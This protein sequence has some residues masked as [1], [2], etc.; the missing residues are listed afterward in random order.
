VHFGQAQIQNEQVKFIVG[1][2]G[3][4][5]FSATGHMV[6]GCTAA[7]QSSQQT[8]GQDLI[9]FCYQNAHR[10]LLLFAV[11]RLCETL[12]G[13]TVNFRRLYRL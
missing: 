12:F 8:I 2:E 1:H 6:N 7:A 9:V 10:R 13:C 4:I 3:C 11:Q 5:G